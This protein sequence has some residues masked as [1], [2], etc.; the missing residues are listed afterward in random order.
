MPMA[1]PETASSSRSLRVVLPSLHGLR[2]GEVGG[3]AGGSSDAR[4]STPVVTR[5]DIKYVA[6]RRRSARCSPSTAVTGP[7]TAETGQAAGRNGR[8]PR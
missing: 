1:S 8:G 5:R 2:S 7:T 6:D 3:R 4:P